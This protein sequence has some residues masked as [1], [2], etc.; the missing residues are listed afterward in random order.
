M[1][2]ALVQ[3]WLE[4]GERIEARYLD[5]LKKNQANSGITDGSE[6][7]RKLYYHFD[8]LDDAQVNEATTIIN[9]FQRGKASGDEGKETVKNFL[10]SCLT[11]LVGEEN[12][13]E[14]KSYLVK[15]G[16]MPVDNSEELRRHEEERRKER[17]RRLREQEEERRRRQEEEDRRRQ[18]GEDHRRQ[19]EEDRRRQRDEE[20]QRRAEESRR[21]TEKYEYDIDRFTEEREQYVVD[22][23]KKKKFNIPWKSVGKIFLIL[24]LIY[25]LFMGIGSLKSC[26]SSSRSSTPVS[27]VTE[28]T[29]S[30]NGNDGNATADTSAEDDQDFGSPDD[31]LYGSLPEGSTEY[32]GDMNGYPIEFVITKLSNAGTLKAEY[33]NVNYQTT[34]TL[35]GESLPAQA[36]DISFYGKENNRDWF[37]NLS[38]DADNITGTAQGDNKEFK[39]VLHRKGAGNVSENTDNTE[40]AGKILEILS[41]NP[42]PQAKKCKLIKVE[43]NESS[44]KIYGEYSSDTSG[45]TV[46][47]NRTAYIV[48]EDGRQLKVQS[49]QGIPLA[50][51]KYTF[52]SAGTVSFVITF[53]ALPAGTTQFDF[54]ESED[55]DSWRFYDIKLSNAI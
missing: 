5:I 6:Y 13:K 31:G 48:A 55:A 15:N 24:I 28:T 43:A 9:S 35:E 7:F 10:G 3:K 34:M 54:I 12:R 25:L 41:Y 30:N 26:I 50:P 18:E 22:K 8:E 14:L 29:N 21:E 46:W 49:S 39:I 17:E 11:L 1:D 47:W 45:S 4:Q 27:Q 40:T 23:M 36:G 51:D 19:E 44:T 52:S 42:T 2:E 16:L 20:R 33:K 37:F 32:V 38:G 53:P